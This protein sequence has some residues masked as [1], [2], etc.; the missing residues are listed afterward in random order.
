MEEAAGF[1]SVTLAADL[2]DGQIYAV[3]QVFTV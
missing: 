1:D 3:F 2:S